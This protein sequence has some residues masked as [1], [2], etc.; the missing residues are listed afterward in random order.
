MHTGLIRFLLLLVSCLPTAWSADLQPGKDYEVL[1]PAQPTAQ[2]D[3]IVVTEF[4]SYQCPHCYSFFPAVTSWVA[5]LPKDVVFEREAVSVGYKTWPPAAQTF[6]TLRAMGKLGELNNSLDG[7]IFSAI[8]KQGVRF[9]DRDGIAAWMATQ[10]INAKQFASTFDSFGVQ[11]AT[12]G[13]ERLA[14]NHKVPSIPSIVID[15]KYL[16]SIE[17][18]PDYTPQLAKLDQLIAKARAE[19]ARR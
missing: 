14:K 6:Y 12:A 19:K 11:S 3:K 15:G 2:R 5:K 7:A 4:F 10:K 8:H 9:A 13:G 16:V 1:Q 18:R 17:D